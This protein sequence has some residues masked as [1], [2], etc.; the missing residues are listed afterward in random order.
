MQIK[1]SLRFHPIT[2]KM[3]IY[4][5]ENKQVLEMIQGKSDPYPL[6]VGM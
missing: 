1:I 3:A 4:N 5:Q 6:L 2:D